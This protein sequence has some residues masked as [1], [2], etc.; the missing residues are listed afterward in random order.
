MLKKVVQNSVQNPETRAYTLGSDTQ[1]SSNT[2]VNLTLT[3]KDVK[4]IEIPDYKVKG[5]SLKNIKGYREKRKALKNQKEYEEFISQ[6]E[7]ALSIFDN[8]DK[9]YDVNV[10]EVIMQIAEDVFISDKKMGQLKFDACVY[11]AKRFFND[12][13]ELVSILLEQLLPKIKKSSLY[14]RNKKRVR[15]FFLYIGQLVFRFV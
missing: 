4:P 14:R 12:D 13:E 10:L 8:S 15:R 11:V 1:T 9:K 2:P 3:Q 5:Y 6:V 7:A